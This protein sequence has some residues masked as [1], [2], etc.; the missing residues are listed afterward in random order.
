M[1]CTPSIQGRKTSCHAFDFSV[2]LLVTTIVSTARPYR[3][4]RLVRLEALK[5][6]FTKNCPLANA[7]AETLELFSSGQTRHPVPL[8]ALARRHPIENRVC[9][10]QHLLSKALHSQIS[11]CSHR[12]FVSKRSF[13]IHHLLECDLPFSC[14]LLTWLYLPVSIAGSSPA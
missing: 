13:S 4:G 14:H 3:N 11:G 1:P 2:L 7:S 12:N 9:Q 5:L 6:G 8:V 10:V